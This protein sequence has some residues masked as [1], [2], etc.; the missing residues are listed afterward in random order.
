MHNLSIANI[1]VLQPLH[2]HGHIIITQN[3]HFT[4]GFT[5]GVLCVM[6][7]YKHFTALKVF[8]ALLIHPSFTH[9]LC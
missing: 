4:L 5:L 6:G 1:R 9:N 8:R 3:S 2:P 7:F